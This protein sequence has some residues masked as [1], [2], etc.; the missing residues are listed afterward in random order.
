MYELLKKEFCLSMHPIT[1]MMI[2]LS[3]MVLI[4]NYSYGVLFFYMTLA[5]FFTCLMSRENKDEIYCMML[6]V[7]KRDIVKARIVFTVIC[8]LLQIGILVPFAIL[9]QHINP[10]ANAAGIDANMILF[11]EGFIF[12]GIFNLIYFCSYYKDISK[13]GVSFVKASIVFMLCIGVDACCT[14]MIPFVRDYL[15]TPDPQYLGI[16]LVILCVGIVTYIVLTMI[17]YENSA[18]L[19]EEQD[20]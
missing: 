2:G 4:P 1:P 16:K 17:A 12:F 5:T 7:A 3:T 19:F 10:V 13:V 9:R 8:Q 15:D 6:P 14:H 20:L 18:K 11:A